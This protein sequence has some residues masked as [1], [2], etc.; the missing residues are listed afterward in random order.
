MW[1][2]ALPTG[3]SKG[4]TSAT[5]QADTVKEFSRPMIAVIHWDVAKM[6]R[7]VKQNVGMGK[8]T[9]YPSHSSD[10]LKQ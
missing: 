4:K 1:D 5:K 9:L 7:T 3:E 10:G 8:G 6:A 2:V